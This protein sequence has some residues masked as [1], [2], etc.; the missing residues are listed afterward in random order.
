MRARLCTL[1]VYPPY[2]IKHPLTYLT[3][4]VLCC[5]CACA[6]Y[7]FIFCTYMIKHP[8]TYLTSI[9]LCCETH[10]YM[11]CVIVCHCVF[12]CLC[13]YLYWWQASKK[14]L[15][16]FVCLCVCVCLCVFVCVSVC[17]CVCVVQRKSVVKPSKLR[18]G[19][20]DPPGTP[21]LPRQPPL[22]RGAPRPFGTPQTSAHAPPGAP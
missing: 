8:L 9:V 16:V 6:P 13:V 17:V 12:V 1:H 2:M 21:G 5:V 22:L 18:G 20:R 11:S 10:T 19:V 14:G 4:F 15:C 7:M 3:S